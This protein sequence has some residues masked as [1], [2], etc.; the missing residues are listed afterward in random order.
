MK[1]KVY[2]SDVSDD[3]WAFVDPYLTLMTEAAPQRE[4][5]LQEVLNGLRWIVRAGAA[6]RM[7][8]H[9]LPPWYTVYQQGQR[10][11]QADVFESIVH[12]LRE[13]LRLAQGGVTRCPRP[14]FSIA[15]RCNRLR[16]VGR[17]QAMTGPNAA[18]ARRST[19]QWIPS[20]TCWCCM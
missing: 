15:A 17:G 6:W 5:S 7:M 2:P 19:W 18:G 1:R 16:K 20:A 13:L 12:D 4:H 10:W 14:R 11:L 3:E 8:L 9:D